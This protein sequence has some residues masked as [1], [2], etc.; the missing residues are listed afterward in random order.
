LRR[1][2]REW[3][4]VDNQNGLGYDS[5]TVTRSIFDSGVLTGKYKRRFSDGWIHNCCC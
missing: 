5:S 2:Q 3:Q 4:F 1:V